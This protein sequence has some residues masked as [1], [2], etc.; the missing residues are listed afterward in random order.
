MFKIKMNFAKPDNA[1]W[2]PPT[3]INYRT[4]L[5]ENYIIPKE[6]LSVV[7]IF[8][9][10][11][12]E[13]E[14]IAIWKNEESYIKFNNDPIV[15]SILSSADEFSNKNGITKS[16]IFIGNITDVDSDYL[17]YKYLFKNIFQDGTE[18]PTNL[19]MKIYYSVE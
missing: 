8:S 17:N 12:N 6:I 19:F 18:I 7:R 16:Q 5:V 14:F 1:V 15:S 4:Y 13:Y 10:D 3:Q 2:C 11:L 9:Y